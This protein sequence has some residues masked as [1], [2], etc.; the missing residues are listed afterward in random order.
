MRRRGLCRAAANRTGIDE[1]L[2]LS[3]EVARE[4]LLVTVY[5]GKQTE[6]TPQIHVVAQNGKT[7]EPRPV[8]VRRA[9]VHVG[10][11]R[12]AGAPIRGHSP[13]SIG[14]APTTPTTAILPRRD[15][16]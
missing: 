15:R 1:S 7:E 14:R 5:Q 4:D 9:A 12:S 10:A 16:A 6:L 8:Y 13:H 2:V 11:G 3:A